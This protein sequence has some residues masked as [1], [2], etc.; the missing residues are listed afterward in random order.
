MCRCAVVASASPSTSAMSGQYSGTT[1][2]VARPATPCRASRTSSSAP[3]ERSRSTCGTSTSQLATS[4]LST[5]A[6]RRPPTDSFRSGTDEWASSPSRSPRPVTSWCSSASRSRAS[7]RHWVSSA[8]RSRSVRFG[9]PARCRASSSPSATRRSADACS[10]ASGQRT[11]GVVD[12]RA[13]VPQRVPDR[14]RPVA[15]PHARVVHEHHVEVAVRRELLAAVP[16]DGDQGDPA[17]RAPGP[18]ERLRAQLV[19]PLG[20]G[21]CGRSRSRHSSR[22]RGVPS[23]VPRVTPVLRTSPRRDGRSDPEGWDA[24]GI[25]C[26][27]LT[28]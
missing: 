28:G 16:A 13:R 11:H 17:L 8:L 20:C 18:G 19:G 27:A 25:Q 7:R 4:A 21:R 15:R 6:S 26:L 22:S 9:S 14:A 12:V 23:W 2:S 24:P 3:R 10:A 5:V 1:R